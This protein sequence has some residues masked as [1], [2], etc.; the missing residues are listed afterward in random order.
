M[1]QLVGSSLSHELETYGSTVNEEHRSTLSV[2]VLLD[3]DGVNVRD[4]QHFGFVGLQS[5]VAGEV[6]ANARSA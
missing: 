1:G 4:G 3:A 2:A 6:G 5:S